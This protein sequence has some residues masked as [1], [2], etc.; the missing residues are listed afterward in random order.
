MIDVWIANGRF[1]GEPEWPPSPAR[2]FQALVAAA[3]PRLETDPTCVQALQWLEAMAPPL[4]AAPVACMGQAIKYFVPNNDLDAM[5]AIP[6][7]VQKIRT[8]KWVRP[9]I[10]DG[11]IPL[12][13]VWELHGPPGESRAVDICEIAEDLYQLGRGIDM[14]WARP[15]IVSEAE[16]WSAL[17]SEPYQ[18][19]RPSAG[20]PVGGAIYA[21]PVPGS[22]ESLQ[23]R[24]EAASVRFVGTR[25]TTTFRQP[26]KARFSRIV[27]NATPPYALFELRPLHGAGA[28]SATAITSTVRL[29]ETL[30][31]A[32]AD[33]LHEALG[34][35]D[36]GLVASL[37]G[38][39]QP[40][41][42]TPTAA[43]RIRLI[44]LPSIGHEHADPSLR[45]LL[46][47]VPAHR[48]SRADDVFW[49]FSGLEFTTP[50]GAP[51][52]LVRA[53]DT[54]M[55]VRYVGAGGRG[56][57][58]FRSI[59]ASALPASRRRMDPS[60]AQDEAKPADERTR[61]E[62]GARRAVMQA[63]RH[64]HVDARPTHVHVQRE[65]FQMHGQRA[66]AFAQGTRFPK[67]RLWHVELGFAEPVRGPLVIGDGRFLG[68]GLM[69]PE[70]RP[71]H[72]LAFKIL[73]GK[74]PGANP[75]EVAGALRRATMAR[76]QSLL[77]R[78]RGLPPLIS[79]HGD[80]SEPAEGVPR[81]AYVHD[82]TRDRLILAIL[83]GT[84]RK[85]V[86]RSEVEL[87]RGAMNG[88]TDLRAGKAG[89]FQLAAVR[90]EGDDPLF[91]PSPTWHSITP[92]RV[93]RHAKVGDA[94]AALVADAEL[95]LQ[96][97][98]L[99][100]ARIVVE[101]VLARPGQGLGGHLR[102]SFDVAVAGPILLG[103]TRFKG[104]GLFAGSPQPEP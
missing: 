36:C 1:H 104:G 66:E 39:A 94:Q 5:E 48:A 81:V 24:H 73:A 103:R 91:A 29:T 12:R 58:T 77:R 60:R 25:G 6:E 34:P 71:L 70:D 97:A 86:W 56:S 9:R 15:R 57:Q 102:L 68:L 59:T 42:P 89:R 2:L 44:A 52:M 38:K 14:A 80:N 30:R 10:F 18:I 22:L 90:L 7:R 100:R 92:Y 55:R 101:R 74:S 83:P 23:V 67:E 62:A 21:C 46:V 69:V 98:G 78:G 87:L 3:S 32:A 61:E 31:D 16:L 50:A 26:P 84:E 76:V 82:P 54:R 43:D 99:P 37:R 49:A 20:A 17:R 41:E 11:D 28:L 27:Y 33:L 72:A 85:E 75:E 47:E 65:P 93:N 51:A 64:A 40:G 4:M 88:F 13:Y 96:Q 95:A 19:Y 79:G 63:L 53:D 45:R 8:E 35:N